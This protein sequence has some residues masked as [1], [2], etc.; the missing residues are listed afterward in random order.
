MFD[1]APSRGVALLE[2][3][4][5]CAYLLF[6]W[7]R[8]RRTHGGL[9]L[10]ELSKA[11]AINL[12]I[13]CTIVALDP[14]HILMPAAEPGSYHVQGV[15]SYGPLLS[16][17]AASLAFLYMG[18]L[19]LRGW[20]QSMRASQDA[21]QPR[22]VEESSR[23]KLVVM[24]LSLGVVALANMY[25]LATAQNAIFDPGDIGW[26][27][28]LAGA[29]LFLPRLLP[30]LHSPLAK[31]STRYGLALLTLNVAALLL[32]K[33][34]RQILFYEEWRNV[35]LVP[36]AWANAPASAMTGLVLQALR[37]PTMYDPTPPG[38][39]VASYA[40]EFA[41]LAI[42]WFFAGFV[43]VLVKRLLVRARPRNA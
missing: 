25:L 40:V 3:G 42:W 4:A 2:F 33:L 1:P 28:V 6:A 12:A 34:W 5:Y 9:K 30:R 37:I 15:P 21:A 26:I 36:L 27:V 11:T 7:R 17:I 13:L 35:W 39:K 20:F 18:F 32:W 41:S 8:V 24:R 16:L 23:W 14:P 38:E 31:D 19:A 10:H 22:T 29:W 43:L